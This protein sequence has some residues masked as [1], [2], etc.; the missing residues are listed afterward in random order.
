MKYLKSRRNKSRMKYHVTPGKWH[1]EA[2]ARVSKPSTKTMSLSLPLSRPPSPLGTERRLI[3][4]SKQSR[5]FKVPDVPLRVTRFSRVFI[6]FRAGERYAW[7]NVGV[8]LIVP[9]GDQDIPSALAMLNLAGIALLNT[10]FL[11][12][13]VWLARVPRRSSQDAEAEKSTQGAGT[14]IRH[15]F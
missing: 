15:V 2:R 9:F 7:H 14:A 8:S 11:Y 10:C 6:Q 13:I 5:T 3:T 12:R 1:S 4:Q